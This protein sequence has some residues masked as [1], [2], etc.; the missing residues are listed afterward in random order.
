MQNPFSISHATAVIRT[1]IAGA[2][3]LA[4][5]TGPA[6]GEESRPAEDEIVVIA[7][8][9]PLPASETGASVTVI[10]AAEI[11]TRQYQFVA[12]A[13]ADAAGLSIARNGAFGGQAALRIRGEAS[14][15]TLVMI[16]G[17]VVNDPAAPGG[18][19]NFGDL[20]VADIARIEI[21]RGPQ[22]ILY[23]SEAI[24]GVVAI[25]TR[26][27][28]GAPSLNAFVE[29]GSFATFRGGA[30]LTGAGS[31]LDYGLTVSG[32]TTDGV[33]RADEADGAREADGLER[34][35]ASA[36]LGA[37]LA[38][39]FRLESSLRYNHALTEFDGFPPP[40]FTLAD[41]DD[42]E[43]SESV[44]A[45][46]RAILTLFDGRSENIASIGYH[47]IERENRLGEMTTF[48]SRGGRISAEYLARIRFS[49]RLSLVAGAKS[50]R[51]RIDTAEADED[52]VVNS[53]YGLVAV[54]PV[55]PLTVTAGARHDDH[56]TFGGETTA[57]VTA[58]YAVEAADLTLRG[59]W[60]EGFAA[61]TLFQLNFVCC[62]GT[63][64]NRDLRP[65]TST[66]WEAGFDKR[67]GALATLRA[68]YFRQRTENQIDFDFFSGAFVNLDETLRRG[69]EA[70][71]ALR[72][73]SALDLHVAYAFV[74]GENEQTGAPLLRQPR[75]AATASADWRATAA[76][77]LGATLRY[78]GE[79]NDIGGIVDD[80]VRVDL[81]GAYA[82][83]E[84]IE[85]YARLE[86][87]FDAQYQDVLGFGEPGI[88]VFGG[89]RARL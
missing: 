43:E 77:S 62:G 8:K 12:D 16:D 73:L 21:L 30:G 4:A 59:S 86:N 50:E 26:R 42:V 56:E 57:R 35:T 2:G 24:G 3:C 49:E 79:E 11:E 88:A 53:V 39:N 66:G 23:G 9:S 89:V 10:D 69:V 36:N 64:P 74:K 44:L 37:D 67:F 61:P 82:V 55:A 60:G 75:H 54:K 5:L 46:G 68:T 29:G 47:R 13:L 72:P 84:K 15:R 51:T 7:T 32:L 27:G 65:E 87:A 58:A 85:L 41:T 78:N 38:E 80:F 19:F 20:D 45:A 22:S 1:L 18:G 76:L 14:G 83:N 40:D 63:A 28:A 17:V 70:E 31:R 33:S 71:L 48:E 34:Y 25:T 6:A 52:V 81:R